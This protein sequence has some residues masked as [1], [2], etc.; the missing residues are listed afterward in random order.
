MS[1]GILNNMPAS[2][3]TKINAIKEFILAHVINITSTAIQTAINIIVILY[4]NSYIFNLMRV[5]HYN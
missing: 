3:D 5:T 2:T 4:A 1:S